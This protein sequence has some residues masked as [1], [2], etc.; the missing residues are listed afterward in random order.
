M[1]DDSAVIIAN[2]CLF[3]NR[4]FFVFVLLYKKWDTS[5]GRED[6]NLKIRKENETDFP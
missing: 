5:N 4:K 1:F 3:V 6:E 2:K